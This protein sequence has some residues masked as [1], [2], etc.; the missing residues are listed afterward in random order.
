MIRA[1]WLR[2]ILLPLFWVATGLFLTSAVFSLRGH[3]ATIVLLGVMI[4]AVLAM[5]LAIL[6]ARGFSVEARVGLLLFYLL[7]ASVFAG[8]F[9]TFANLRSVD[10]HSIAI[11]SAGQR[12]FPL[13][14]GQTF[15]VLRSC[16][17]EI[18]TMRT[19]QLTTIK[20]GGGPY[21]CGSGSTP[22]ARP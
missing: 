3:P 7:P 5:P 17:G 20:R 4:L 1:R 8:Y 11:T 16:D 12:L 19:A 13:K 21:V 6:S 2:L 10:S 9:S 22:A 15:S 18:F 14:I